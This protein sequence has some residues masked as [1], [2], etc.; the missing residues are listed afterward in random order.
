MIDV[1][2][3]TTVQSLGKRRHGR[4]RVGTALSMA[5]G[6]V[7]STCGEENAPDAQFCASCRSL[8]RMAGRR[9]GTGRAARPA[10][11]CRPQPAVTASAGTASGAGPDAGSDAAQHRFEAAQHRFEADIAA[12]EATVPVD[13]TPTTMTVNVANTSS[14]VD[15]YVV[16]AIDAPPWL[17][18]DLRHRGAPARDPGHRRGAAAGSSRQSLV[19]AQ[20]VSVLL[21]V[22]NTTATLDSR[23]LPVRV[24]VPVVDAPFEVRAEPALLRARDHAPSVCS[25]VVDNSRSNQWA[26]VQLS[27]GDPEDVVRPTWASPEPQCAPGR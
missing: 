2:D 7:C 1:D 21:R 17:S 27:A 10:P 13:G 26:Q 6:I 19:P 12:P 15:G 8:P 4:S 23:D 24:T 11:R 16:E 20:Q 22:R 9:A 14:V 3:P 25:V 18:V 5:P